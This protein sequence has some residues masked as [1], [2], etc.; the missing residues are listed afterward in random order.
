MENWA[1]IECD[2]IHVSNSPSSRHPLQKNK[3]WFKFGNSKGYATWGDVYK[4][5]RVSH[6]LPM[7]QTC[8]LDAGDVGWVW[9]KQRWASLSRD[10]QGRHH[11]LSIVNI[12]WDAGSFARAWRALEISPKEMELFYPA[13]SHRE[14]A[15]PEAASL[16]T[17]PFDPRIV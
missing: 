13:T 9:K 14:L 4:A 17:D 12:K 11:S 15:G 16:F 6:F 10:Y 8:L 5:E 3:M 2:V 7:F 1:L